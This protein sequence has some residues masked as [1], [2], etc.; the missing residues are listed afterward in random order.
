L[1]SLVSAVTDADAQALLAEYREKYQMNTADIDSVLYQAKI[2]LALERML[3]QTGA[4][5]FTTNFEDLHGLEQL[6]GLA[7]QRL[8]EKGC[9]CGGEGDW[10]T[11]ALVRLMKEMAAGLSGGTSFMEDYTYHLAPGNEYILGAHML[12]VCPSVAGETP[13]IEV[14][15]LGIGGKAAPARLVFDGAA[16]DAVCVSLVDMGGRMRMICA[17]VEAVTPVAAM[18]KLPV[19]RLMWKPLP[20]FKT[21]TEA[22]ILAGG[23]HHTAMSFALN[24]GHMRDLARIWGVEFVHIGAGTTVAALEKELFWNDGLRSRFD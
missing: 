15:P 21:A 1:V 9:G 12:E 13:K 2:E 22:W 4:G 10:K 7:V 5:A 11:A 16:G 8:M 23:A 20:D 24:A 18:P 3:E 6:P 17:D 14:H 19:A